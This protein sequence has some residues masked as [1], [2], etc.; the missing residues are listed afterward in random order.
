MQAP[1]EPQ[2]PMTDPIERLRRAADAAARRG[3]TLR[4]LADAAAPLYQS[5][6]EAQKNRFRVL[7][8]F[9]AGHRMGWHHRFGSDGMR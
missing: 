7:A 9:G 5:L 4:E 3:T 6:D 1:G 8:R 2:Q